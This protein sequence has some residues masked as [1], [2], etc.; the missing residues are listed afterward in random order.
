MKIGYFSY[1]S[2]LRYQ[3][4]IHGSL[5][6]QANRIVDLIYTKYLRA[7]IECQGITRVETYSFPKK[8]IREAI[9]NALAHK[10]YGTLIPI[11]IRVYDDRICIAND[12]IFPRDWTIADLLG[13]HRSRLYNPLI[14]NTFFPCRFYRGMGKRY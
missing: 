9:F 5:L 2:D 12:C 11:Q 7:N 14:A 4:E 1:D 10:Y 13:S 8:A 6:S 3:D